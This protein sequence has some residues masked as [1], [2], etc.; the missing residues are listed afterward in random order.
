VASARSATETAGSITTVTPCSQEHPTEPVREAVA[1]G[2][3]LI[4]WRRWL[5]Q[6]PDSTTSARFRLVL[7]PDPRDRPQPTTRLAVAAAVRPLGGWDCRHPRSGLGTKPPW[8]GSMKRGSVSTS[9]T[10]AFF[11]LL[12]CSGSDENG[13]E[14][15]SSGIDGSGL[16][17]N[18]PTTGPVRRALRSATASAWT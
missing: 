18:R 12:A 10:T 11:L 6:G 13:S 15:N 16:G 8:R 1:G 14:S 5:V 3:A 4:P 2:I 17:A 7:L 9:V